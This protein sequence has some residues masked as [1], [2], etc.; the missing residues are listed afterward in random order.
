MRGAP[1]HGTD[2]PDRGGISRRHPVAA[3]ILR[4]WRSLTGGPGLD[5]ADR[6]T[7]VACSAGAD[8][9]ALALALSLVDPGP[10]LVHVRHDIRDKT[11]TRADADLVGSLGARLG[12]ATEI[13]EA[14]VSGDPGNLEAGAR[15]ARYD[16]LAGVA[17]RE[18]I[19]FIATAHHADDQLETVLMRLIRGSGLR[20]IGGIRDHA[21]LQGGARL[22]RP[23]L[24]VTR[25]EARALAAEGGIQWR[26]DETNEDRSLLRN[27]VRA[28]VL[29]ALHAIDSE[30]ARRVSVDA[31]AFR[32]GAEALAALVSARWWNNATRDGVAVTLDRDELRSHCPRGAIE[33]LVRL[34]IDE[35]GNGAGH[36]A[37]G[38]RAIGRVADA[39]LD[40]STER[41]TFTLGP[42][43]VVVHAGAVVF[44]P[45][46][47]GKEP[48]HDAKPDPQTDPGKES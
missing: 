31:D 41:R 34:A 33:T 27:R 9:C 22:V 28:E 18:G 14:P 40:R 12:C 30:V 44:S 48:P 2:T 42:M 6:R 20:G 7:I 17:R 23:M 43:L 4:R 29:P 47:T 21:T 35:V 38:S 10:L 39:V 46:P 32:S 36:D 16:A 45:R 26:E 24:G 5:D 25:A 37:A 3:R 19:R 8:S 15:A 1:D 11:T 13:V